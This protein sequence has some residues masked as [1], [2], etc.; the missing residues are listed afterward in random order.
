MLPFPALDGGKLLFL[1][2]R[3]F[4]GKVISDEIE[5]KIH[6]AGILILFGLMIYLV[7]QDVDRFI[8]N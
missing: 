5:A 3:L 6:F 4:T 8:L 7:I 1:I 2:I